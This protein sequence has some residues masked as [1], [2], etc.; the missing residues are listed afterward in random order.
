MSAKLIAINGSYK[1]WTQRRYI[2]AFG[3]HGRTRLLV[4]ANGIE[5]ALDECID[6]LAE[7]QPG[8]LCDENVNEE[9]REALADGCGESEAWERATADTIC[10]GNAGH[11]LLAWECRILAEDPDRATIKAIEAT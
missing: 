9:Y 8:L 5:D 10:G 7:H 3:F 11:H 6:W 2:L 4:W 1:S